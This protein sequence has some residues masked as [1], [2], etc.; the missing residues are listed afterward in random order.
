MMHN[1]V[2]TIHSGQRIGQQTTAHFTDDDDL[3]SLNDKK[4]LIQEKRW[5]YPH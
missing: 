2:S 5:E 4:I 3:Y 1:F